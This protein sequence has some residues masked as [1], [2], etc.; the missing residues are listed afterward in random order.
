[1]LKWL[2]GVLLAALLLIRPEAAANGAREAM[3]QW[4]HHV[5]PALLPFMLLLPLLTCDAAAN[6]YERLLGGIMRRVYALPGAAAPALA[7]GML[8]G[9]PAGCAAARR[10]DGLSVGQ[11]QRLA[12]SACGLSP[13][14][15][16]AVIGTLLNSPESGIRLYRAQIL[17]QLTMPILLK[18]F[19]RDAAPAPTMEDGASMPPLWNVLSVGC[20]M[21]FFGAMAAALSSLAGARWGNICLCAMDVT[22]GTRI[23]SGME[24]PLHARVAALS[25]LTGF[26]GLCVCAQ[27]TALLRGIVHPAA[28]IM[29]RMMAGCVS[30][31]FA[32]LQYCDFHVI[33]WSW[34]LP[35]SCLI[36]CFMLIPVIFSLKRTI[37]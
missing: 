16:I 26:G 8:A 4:Y 2:S 28:F 29:Y 23:I 34:A 27:N 17:T 24:A 20:Y 33:N 18:P 3:A 25:M 5:A 1:M 22:S 7:V 30:A 14:F 21:A 13:A 19:C 6:A 37:F 11:M 9:S 12:I 32:M 10:I 15:Y 36:S 31:G 35:V